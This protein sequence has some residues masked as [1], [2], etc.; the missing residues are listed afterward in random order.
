MRQFES[1]SIPRLAPRH[2]MLKSMLP[3]GQASLLQGV[4]NGH[5]RGAHDTARPPCRG[6]CHGHATKRRPPPDIRGR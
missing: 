1:C 2:A 3:M 5:G 4:G 6:A